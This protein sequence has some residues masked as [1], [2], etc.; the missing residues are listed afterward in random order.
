MSVALWCVLI[1]AVMPVLIVAIAKYGTKLDNHHPR[2]WAQSSLEGYRKRAYAAHQNAYEAFP[3]F[4]ASVLVSQFLNVS[5]ARIDTLAV[6]F[7][8]ARTAYVGFYLADQAVLR[9]VAWFIGWL[10]CIVI[11]ISGWM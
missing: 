2:D 9:S 5:Q 7:I 1:A 11:F 8:V 3:F 10:I 4:A 6:S